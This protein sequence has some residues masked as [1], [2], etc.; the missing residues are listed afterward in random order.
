MFQ[1]FSEKEYDSL[2]SGWNDKLQFI[3]DDNH[4]WNLFSAKKP[5]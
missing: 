5:F 1:K 4:N 2:V 3:A